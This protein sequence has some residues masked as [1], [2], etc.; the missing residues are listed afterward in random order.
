MEDFCTILLPVWVLAEGSGSWESAVH[1]NLGTK[2]GHYSRYEPTHL[3]NASIS[4]QRK[5]YCLPCAP[6]ISEAERPKY[7][8]FPRKCKKV[9]KVTYVLLV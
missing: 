7:C 8:S 2:K 6:S 1:T 9:Q 5:C 3:N 4:L